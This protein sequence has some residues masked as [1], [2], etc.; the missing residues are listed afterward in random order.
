MIFH[1]NM[2]VL[3][4]SYISYTINIVII[5]IYIHIIYILDKNII[6]ML[7][8]LICTIHLKY[9]TGYILKIYNILCTDY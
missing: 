9:N 8:K 1:N 5:I 4:V 7:S 2:T 3:E 6:L